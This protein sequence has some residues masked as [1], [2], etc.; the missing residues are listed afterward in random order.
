MTNT[1]ISQKNLKQN[2]YVVSLPPSSPL[3][4]AEHRCTC[5][6]SARTCGPSKWAKEHVNWPRN[7][8]DMVKTMTRPYLL[9]LWADL[10]VLVL[11]LKVVGIPWV[12]LC[13][14]LQLPSPPHPS[15][16]PS[17]PFRPPLLTLPPSPPHPSA[18]P[19]SPFRPPLLTLP[20]SPPHPSTLPSP[21]PCQPSLRV[22]V[23]VRV[24]P[25]PSPHPCTPPFHPH[26]LA[27]YH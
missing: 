23:R 25:L 18:L 16:L 9:H 19:S 20:P 8:G 6:P 21:P 14:A 24:R 26:P 11:V 27:N 1:K 7:E 3:P 4:R 12:H 2:M 22:R 17:S 13:S 5:D 15:T 10:G